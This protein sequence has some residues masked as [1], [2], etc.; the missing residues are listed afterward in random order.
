MTPL[1]RT[2]PRGLLA[3]LAMAMMVA[4]CMTRPPAP[5]DERA[6]VPYT[7]MLPPPTPMVREPETRVQLYTV[8]RGETLAQIALDHGLDYRELAVWNNIENPNVIRVGQVLALGPPGSTSASAVPSG[9]VT[10]PLVATPAIAPSNESRALM[11]SPG[12]GNTATL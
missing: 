10:T 12:H 2:R 3:G 6:P 1:A 9:V 5:V 7:P 4:A 11:I 8:K